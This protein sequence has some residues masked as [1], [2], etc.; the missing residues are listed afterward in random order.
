MTDKKNASHERYKF[1]PFLGSSHHWALRK[2]SLLPKSIAV[3]D[4]GAGSGAIG[5]ALKQMGF[6]KLAA[7][8]IDLAALEFIKPIYERVSP[9]L[10]LYKDDKFDLIIV[11]DVLEHLVQ[12]QKEYQLL[13]NLLSPGGH[14]LISVPNTAH[15][16]VRIQLLFGFLEYTERGLLDRTHLQFFT[17]KRLKELIKSSQSMELVELDSSIDPIELLLPEWIWDNKVFKVFSR[18]RLMIARLAPGLFAY[19]HLALLR[20]SG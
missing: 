7:T 18:L 8:E 20:K 19:Q 3:L 9:S 1:K 6:S 5:A 14:M 15:W 16:M 17:R 11:L 2:I 13:A 10:E 4:V 12:P